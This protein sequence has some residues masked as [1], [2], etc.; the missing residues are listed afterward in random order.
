MPASQLLLCKAEACAILSAAYVRVC[1]MAIVTSFYFWGIAA[2]PEIEIQLWST[3]GLPT[4]APVRWIRQ[5]CMM[6]QMVP[7][8]QSLTCLKAIEMK[9]GNHRSIL[10]MYGG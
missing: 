3:L 7:I 9:S 4:L 8:T 6:L 1:Q 5:F 10:Q 2:S